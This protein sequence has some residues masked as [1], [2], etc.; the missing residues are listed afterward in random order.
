M[1][2]T[3]ILAIIAALV[4]LPLWTGM[5]MAADEP[6]PATD[7]AINP[8]DPGPGGGIAPESETTMTTEGAV[9]TG[10]VVGTNCWLARGLEGEKYRDSAI[11][12]ARNGTPLSILTDAGELI[13]PVT[14]GNSGN[15]LPDM[16][17]V[18]KYAEQRVKV[19]GK[20]MRRGKER[21]IVVDRIEAAPAPAKARTFATKETPG[22]EIRGR[23]VDLDCWIAKGARATTDAKCIGDCAT[24][25]DPLVLVTRGGRV[26]F[27][28]SMTM[29]S[30]PVGAKW[31]SGYCGREVVV[32]GTVV[33]RG[34]A[35]GI[36]IAKVTPVPVK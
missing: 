10:T 18:T 22:T 24:S 15:Y 30:S 17:S 26:Y 14:I 6:V 1:R 31:L 2:Y 9:I 12:C 21:A 25:G 7:N 32:N 27:P 4:A 36:V 35:R 34:D 28:V 20:L 23:V 16:Q 29:P 11:A 13:Y 3:R 19:T 33:D 8:G 5:L